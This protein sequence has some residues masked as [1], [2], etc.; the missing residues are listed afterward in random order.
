MDMI[1]FAVFI[2][3]LIGG[4]VSALWTGKVPAT[5]TTVVEGLPA[6]VV[7][8]LLL[9]AVPLSIAGFVLNGPIL[10]SVGVTVGPDSVLPLLLTCGPLLGCPLLGVIVGIATAKPKPVR[11]RVTLDPTRPPPPPV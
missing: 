3:L 11:L 6:R 10:K 2:C 1:A 8:G 5:K 9:V 7:G 4:G